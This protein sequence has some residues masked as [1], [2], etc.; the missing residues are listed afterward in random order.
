MFEAATTERTRAA[1]QRAH[2]ERGQILR[3]AWDWLFPSSVSR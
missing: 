2:Q 1:L 3:D